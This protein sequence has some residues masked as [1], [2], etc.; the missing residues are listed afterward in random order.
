MTR[1]PSIKTLCTLKDVTSETARKIRTVI[2]LESRAELEDYAERFMPRTRDWLMRCYHRPSAGNLR[3][4][5]LDELLMTHGVEYLFKG[6]EG[7][8]GHCS[9]PSDE[10]LCEYLNA[11]DTYAPTLLQTGGRWVVGC[12][13]DIAERHI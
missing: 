7:L 8:A 3:A 4:A 11:G 5:M 1:A 6:S 13:G 10:L 9:M 2:K 12:W